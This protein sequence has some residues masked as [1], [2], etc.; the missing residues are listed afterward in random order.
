[1]TH[2]RRVTILAASVA[3]LLLSA[4]PARAEQLYVLGLQ[5]IN[6]DSELPTLI[7]NN[8]GIDVLSFSWGVTNPAS[9]G[10]KGLVSDKPAF[11]DFAVNVFG[12]REVPELVL[13][14]ATGAQ[15]P[16][17]KFVVYE[18]TGEGLVKKYE[19]EF[20]DVKITGFQSAGSSGDRIHHFLSLA[21]SRLKIRIFKSVN[22]SVTT[23]ERSWNLATA[24][25]Q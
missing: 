14:I 13:R 5:G 1:M 4:A 8:K 21:Y 9:I 11:T 18:S 22:G 12:G 7:E 19:L 20:G 2:S 17:A 23:F 10:N 16:L 15:I 25:P 24:T 3:I 6:G